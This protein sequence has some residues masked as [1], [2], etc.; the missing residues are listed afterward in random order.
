MIIEDLSQIISAIFK[1]LLCD[2]TLTVIIK[3]MI[4]YDS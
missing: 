1:L 4:N 3:H 2:H